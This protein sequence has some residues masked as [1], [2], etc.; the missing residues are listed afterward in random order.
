MMSDEQ[1][2][3]LVTEAAGVQPSD[4]ARAK[5]FL[6]EG[7]AKECRVEALA[8][9][10]VRLELGDIGLDVRIDAAEV[11]GTLRRHARAIS[12]RR[13]LFQA[14]WDLMRSGHLLSYGTTILWGPSSLNAITDRGASGLAL[15]SRALQCPHPE[16]VVLP[17]DAAPT[18]V[19]NID[20]LFADADISH[21]HGGVHEAL[22]SSIECLRRGLYLPA[23]AMLAAGAEAE[24]VEC[25]RA[26]ALRAGDAKL[27][28]VV[29]DP[30]KGVGQKV[31]AIAGFLVGHGNKQLSACSVTKGQ[32]LEAQN[33]T[34]ELREGRNALHWPKAQDFTKTFSEAATLLMGAPRHLAALEAI[35]TGKL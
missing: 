6:L 10:W 9:K 25:G 3:L 34:S 22:R 13:A 17:P 33:W 14:V 29:D 2:R 21:L 12:L 4:V 5:P 20:L 16:N 15:S 11:E 30:F 7:A 26:L 8:I 35:R 27:G 23:I 24:W 1:A 18:T 31:A 32:L 19:T 28:E